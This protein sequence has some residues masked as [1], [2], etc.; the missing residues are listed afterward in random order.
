MARR[1]GSGSSHTGPAS[2]AIAVVPCGPGMR[3]AARLRPRGTDALEQRSQHP[4]RVTPAD[5]GSRTVRARRS[6]LPVDQGAAQAGRWD[7]RSPAAAEGDGLAGPGR[8]DVGPQSECKKM[9]TAR[10]MTAAGHGR[11]APRHE[12]PR[13]R[14][15]VAIRAAVSGCPAPPS[16]PSAVPL[17]SRPRHP[18]PTRLSHA[19]STTPP[20]VVGGHR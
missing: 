14:R 4:V 8:P 17:P 9:P 1:C 16:P 13:D 5:D 3:P 19:F 12:I 18:R 11:V 15:N 20:P 10:K 7:G 6:R 2:G